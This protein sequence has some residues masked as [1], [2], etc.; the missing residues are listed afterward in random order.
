[1][2]NLERKGLPADIDTEKLVLGALLTDA[3]AWPVLSELLRAESFTLADHQRI[4]RACAAVA[5]RGAGID[6]VTVAHELGADLPKIGGI[7]RLLEL[8]ENLPKI[9]DLTSYARRLSGIAAK[10]AALSRLVRLY[11]AVEASDEES[12][13]PHLD[14]L[15]EAISGEKEK[16]EWLTPEE[17]VN[18]AGG[19]YELMRGPNIRDVVIPPWKGLA[20]IVPAFS[21]GQ[22]VLVAARPGVGKTIMLSQIMEAAVGQG[23]PA[24]MVSLEMLG[25]DVVT[26]MACARASVSLGRILHGRADRDERER[27][28]FAL[29][30]LYGME[31]RIRDGTA[32]TVPGLAASLRRDAGK[33]KAVFVDY[34]GLMDGPGRT[35]YERVSA[36][37]RAL[38]RL[39]M[40]QRVCVI[41][42]CQINRQGPAENR[43][44]ELHDLRDSGSLEQDANTVLMLHELTEEVGDGRRVDLYVKKQRNGQIGK[45]PMLRIGKYSRLEE[46]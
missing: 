15:T 11:E 45:I 23:L 5:D 28:S 24:R 16:R 19:M 25:Q 14:A 32:F 13:L 41:A 4:W 27:F 36:I 40:E 35:P 2:T 30:E 17:I 12:I 21:P 20:T 29:G 3:D 34:I 22:L 42:A 38:K 43:P 1:M 8:D 10:R 39:A 33:V 7:S 44:P 31:I 6:R 37:S 9:Y 18:Q 46:L 26:R